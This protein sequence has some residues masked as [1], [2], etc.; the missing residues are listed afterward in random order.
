LPFEPLFPIARNQL[1]SKIASYHAINASNQNA[2]KTFPPDSQAKNISKIA[3]DFLHI[4]I[5]NI[6]ESE[7]VRRFLK[8]FG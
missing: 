7:S 3:M 6:T 8:L 1:P 2:K 4:G 5:P